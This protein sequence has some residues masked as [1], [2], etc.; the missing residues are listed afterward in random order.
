MDAVARGL[1]LEGAERLG[2][3]LDDVLTSRF[4]RYF[5]LLVRWN[6]RIQLTTVTGPSE[7][8]ERHFLDSMA[9]VPHLGDAHSLVDVGSG[10]GFPGL[11]VALLRPSL[12]VTVVESI[13]KKA[14]FLE[15]V[16]RELALGNVEV[17]ADR[18]EA[19]VG[20][21]ARFDVAVSRATFAPPEWVQRG[22]PLVAAGGRLIA[23]VVPSEE[24][25][26]DWLAPGWQASFADAVVLP[27]YAPGRALLV[28]SGRR[29]G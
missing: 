21:G 8:V 17:V 24:S 10:A 12:A 29:S 1:L 13:H 3:P 7:V 11:V 18:M 19:V 14:A 9:I 4:E 25:T 2:V 27:P 16:K 22:R 15:A 20:S 5:T 28:L 23:M 6:A 26:V